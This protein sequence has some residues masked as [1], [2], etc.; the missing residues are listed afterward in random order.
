MM[1]FKD[2]SNRSKITMRGMIKDRD[3]R[4]RVQND[5]ELMLEE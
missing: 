2:K 5:L 3:E 4:E 1:E